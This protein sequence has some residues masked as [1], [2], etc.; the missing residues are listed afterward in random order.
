MRRPRA[1]PAPLLSFHR[2]ASGRLASIC[3]CAVVSHQGRTP[4]ALLRPP[5][6]SFQGLVILLSPAGS[7]AVA[8]SM[9]GAT[10]SPLR[11]PYLTSNS[12][13]PAL[14]VPV[15]GWVLSWLALPYAPLPRAPLCSQ[16][17]TNTLKK[18]LIMSPTQLPSWPV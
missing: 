9:E 1:S 4:A 2:H 17:L 3:T 12:C 7:A 5:F 11:L 18:R 8:I 14:Q 16:S 13:P 10:P 15:W 6:E